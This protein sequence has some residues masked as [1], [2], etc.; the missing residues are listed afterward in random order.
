MIDPIIEE[1]RKIRYEHAKHFNFDLHLICEDLIKKEKEC[2][3]LVK[4]LPPK[5]LLKKISTSATYV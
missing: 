2:T 1:I 4:A 3:N 5:K